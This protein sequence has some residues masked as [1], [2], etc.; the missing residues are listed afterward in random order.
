MEWAEVVTATAEIA[1][2]WLDI[3][4]SIVWRVGAIVVIYTLVKEAVASTKDTND[5]RTKND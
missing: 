5:T 3:A 1:A 4:F 2:A